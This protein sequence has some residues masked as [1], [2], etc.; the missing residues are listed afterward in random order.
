V[1]GTEHALAVGWPVALTVAAIVVRERARG[2]RRRGAINEALHELRRP[3]QALALFPHGTGAANAGPATLE[4]ALAALDDLDREVNGG[5][6]APQLR[7]VACR[8]SVEHSV[9]RWRTAAGRSGTAIELR[10]QA[11]SATVLADPRRLA[12][13]LDNLIANSLEHA[14]PPVRVEGTLAGGRVRIAVSDGGSPG[15]GP[16]VGAARTALAGLG[17]IGARSG[18]ARRGH[19]LAVV[20]RIASEHGGRFVVGRDGRQTVAVLELPLAGRAD[21]ATAPAT[22]AA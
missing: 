17:M 15:P 20:A 6:A 4:M 13:A 10:W 14:V 2:A 9:G 11:G 7:P 8:A 12:Q 19:G 5:E 18:D 16:S 21:P 1:S 22:R 3:L